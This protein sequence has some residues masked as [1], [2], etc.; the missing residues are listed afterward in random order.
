MNFYY[1]PGEFIAAEQLSNDIKKDI[2]LKP[3]RIFIS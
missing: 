2:D 3:S 1:N